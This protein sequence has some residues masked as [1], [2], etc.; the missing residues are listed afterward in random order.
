M[1]KTTRVQKF[2]IHQNLAENIS[3]YELQFFVRGLNFSF[4]ILEMKLR[5]KKILRMF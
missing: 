4:I 3:S 2:V 5:E 1:K